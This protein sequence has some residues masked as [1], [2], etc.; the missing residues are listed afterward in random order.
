MT[1]EFAP[2]KVNLTLHVTGR[3][4]D[5]YHLLDSL[6]VFAAVGDVLRVTPAERLT[7]RISGPQARALAAED[8]NLVLRA[9]RAFGLNRGAAIEL[10]KH[11][12]VASGIGGGSADAAAGLRA[13]ARLWGVALPDAA[14]VLRLGADV[15]VCLAGRPVR[16]AGVGETLTP[17]PAL[18]EAWLVLANPGLGVST[19]EVFRA[20]ARRD[21]RAMPEV[22]GFADVRDFA[23]FLRGLRNDMEPAAESLLPVIGTV[24][25]ALAA[26]KGCLLARM[27]GSGA[28]CFGL[29]GAEAQAQEAARAVQAAQPG[30]W[31]QAGRMLS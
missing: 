13:L 11:L 20:L 3:R 26:Q 21:N 17:L 2:A 8:D 10:E 24:R 7:L 15:P 23:G 5:G 16:M 27:S 30:W 22:P 31:V 12:P 1:A 29:F 18:P 19:P 6:V 14:T 4:A 25:A 28:T 9:A